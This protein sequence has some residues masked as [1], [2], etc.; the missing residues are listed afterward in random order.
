[1]R[2]VVQISVSGVA[3]TSNTQSDYIVVALCDDGTVWEMLGTH[4]WQQLPAIPQ[5]VK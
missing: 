4:P 1:M 3:N 5:E 2:K